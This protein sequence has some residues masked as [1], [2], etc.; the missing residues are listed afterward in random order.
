MSAATSALTERAAAFV[1]SLSREQRALALLGFDADQRAGWHYTPRRRPGLRLDHLEEHQRSL[2][3]SMMRAALS[4]VGF[5]KARSIIILE[6]ILGEVTGRRDFRD[7]DNYAF[8]FFGEPQ[9][10]HPWGW[11]FEGHHLS[12]SFAV[13]PGHDVAFTPA[14]Y[15]TNPAVV[16]A[17]HRRAGWRVLKSEHELAF[18][19]LGL[20]DQRQLSEAL[21]ADRTPGDI[22]TGPGREKTLT[23][24]VGLALGKMTREQRSKAVQLIRVYVENIGQR[25]AELRMREILDDGVENIHFA[26]AGATGEDRPHYYRLHGPTMIIEYDNTQGGGNHVHSVWHDPG[27]LFGADLLRE[28]REAHGH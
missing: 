23:E 27:N 12:L 7:P 6:G 3:W 4:D 15:G 19:L 20:L 21:I 16:P 13:V 18:E 1:E 28:H 14:F 2:A 5:D 26:W 9:S 17:G 25:F 22:I 8:V 10:E 24:P 11:R